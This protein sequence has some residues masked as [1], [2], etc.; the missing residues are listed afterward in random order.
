MVCSL[1]F[2][3]KINRYLKFPN[4][5]FSSSQCVSEVEI[6]TN[7]NEANQ[8]IKNNTFLPVFNKFEYSS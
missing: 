4:G 3:P 2:L 8:K 1:K 7:F 6:L 5:K